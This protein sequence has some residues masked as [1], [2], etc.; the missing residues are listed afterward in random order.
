[1]KI[2]WKKIL[3]GISEKELNPYFHLERGEEHKLLE[4]KEALAKAQ[5]PEALH[6]LS[7]LPSS[8]IEQHSVAFS[9]RYHRL[10]EEQMQASSVMIPIKLASI[11]SAAT[12]SSWYNCWKKPSARMLPFRK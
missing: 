12:S 1:M 6:I 10:E 3:F 11:A 4:I 2:N 8:A 7:T 5:L 9:S